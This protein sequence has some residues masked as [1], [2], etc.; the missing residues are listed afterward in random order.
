MSTTNDGGPAFPTSSTDARH[1]LPDGSRIE[2]ECDGQRVGMSLRDYFAAH[3]TTDD[4]EEH[5]SIAC[6]M[7]PGGESRLFTREEA[8]FRYADAMLAAREGGSK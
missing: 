7:H 2:V 6:N 1:F 4:I 3:A 8:K 5:L